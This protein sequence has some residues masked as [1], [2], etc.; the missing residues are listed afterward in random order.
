MRYLKL[1][2]SH[3]IDTICQQYGIINYSINSDGSIDVDGNVIISSK[4][5]DDIPLNFN[6]VTGHFACSNNNLYSLN[7][8]PKSCNSFNCQ[9]NQLTNLIG[10]PIE[11]S[12]NYLCASNWLSSLKGGPKFVGGVFKCDDNTSL[13]NT[14]CDH[15]IDIGGDFIISSFYLRE[16]LRG[17]IRK[18]HR[19]DDKLLKYIMKYQVDYS[20]WK[21]DWGGYK[22]DEYR[23]KELMNDYNNEYNK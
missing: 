10:G 16:P 4:E 3:N 2:E 6:I 5:L 14:A 1:Y 8:C 20:I 17:E 19:L 22:L 23:F 18:T 15:S 9:D 12:D 11:V 21:E 13:D 7:G